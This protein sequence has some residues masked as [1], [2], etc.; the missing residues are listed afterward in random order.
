MVASIFLGVALVV[1]MLVLYALLSAL[2]VTESV[3]TLI[4][5][6]TADPGQSTEASSAINLGTVLGLSVVLAAVNVVLITALS[7]LGAMLYNLVAQLTGGIE[8]T[9]GDRD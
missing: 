5:D 6:V 1:A 2:G 9:L 3:N 8:V 7:T 4:S